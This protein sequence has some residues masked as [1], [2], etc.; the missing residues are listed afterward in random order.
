MRGPC[1]Q[2]LEKDLPHCVRAATK[3]FN[4]SALTGRKRRRVGAASWRVEG[5]IDSY[6]KD[7]KN[8]HISVKDAN[9]ETKGLTL[10]SRHLI[11]ASIPD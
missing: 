7:G 4:A 9:I 10:N 5:C 1:L 2:A 11:L 8:I 3:T 6:N